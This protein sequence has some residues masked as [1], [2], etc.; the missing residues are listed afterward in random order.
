MTSS[1]SAATNLSELYQ[2][3]YY[4]WLQ[5]TAHLLRA[6]Q[7]SALDITNLL[8]EIEDMGRSEK[9]TMYSNLK[10]LLLHLLEYEHQPKKRSSSWKSSIIEHRQ[11]LQQA[12]KGCT[13]Q[14]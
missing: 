10:I 2:K 7:L 5:A 13:H 3:D 8:E 9:R 14:L 6:R 1:P 4:Q 11:R 12:L